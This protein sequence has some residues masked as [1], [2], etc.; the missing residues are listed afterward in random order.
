[1]EAVTVDWASDG[2]LRIALSRPDKMNA[3]DVVMRDELLAS[4]DKALVDPATR[5]IL[6]TGAGGNFSAGGDI[7]WMLRQ[8]EDYKLT[9]HRETMTFVRRLAK[10]PKPTIAAIEGACA[11]GG[12]GFALCCDYIV[13]DE[14]ARFG[15]PFLRIGLVPD[16]GS[17]YLLTRR[18]G[19]QAARRLILE[20]RMIDG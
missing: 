16:M 19:D 15:V 12:A 14:T 8:S 5:V 6:L 9:Y 2:V 10:S 18:I 20:N 4:L 3:I 1:M 13:M 7:D 11:G 17:A